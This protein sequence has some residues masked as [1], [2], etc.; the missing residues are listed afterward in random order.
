M[1]KV[2][3]AAAVATLLSSAPASAVGL[4]TGNFFTDV[5]FGSKTDDF[6]DGVALNANDVKGP[7]FTVTAGNTLLFGASVFG[8]VQDTLT[9][10]FAG[11][12]GLSL[13][14]LPGATSICSYFQAPGGVNCTQRVRFDQVGSYSGTI[15][16]NLL[17]SAPDY[18]PVSTGAFAGDGATFAFRVSVVAAPV[19]EPS[20]WALMIGGFGVVG[21]AARRRSRTTVTYA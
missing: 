6:L 13:E 17:L 18:R 14:D 4:P 1:R 5:R 3:F 8:P 20:N 9:S 11:V 21:A 15:A 16:V 2:L 10:T 12:P 7:A 19:P